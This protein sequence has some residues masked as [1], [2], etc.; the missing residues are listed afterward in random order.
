MSLTWYVPREL[1]E[2]PD[3]L[4]REGVVPHGGG[5]LLLRGGVGRIRG[6]VDLSRLGLD[7]VR[8]EQGIVTSGDD[9]SGVTR[10]LRAGAADY[11]AAD[12]VE[13]LLSTSPRT[14]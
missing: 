12:V 9:L 10:F 14:A 11:S 3:L 6:L 1:R 5:T 2:V 13:T 8:V 7:G 4:A